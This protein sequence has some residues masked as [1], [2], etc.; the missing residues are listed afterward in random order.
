MK[1]KTDFVTNSSSSVFIVAWPCPIND[2]GDVKKHIWRDDKAIQVFKDVQHGKDTRQI[3]PKNRE[4]IDII[5]R[6]L[7][8][9][10]LQDL[11]QKVG[12]ELG[13]FD[14]YDKF[15]KDFMYR[16]DISQEELEKN[17]FS[18]SLMWKE[19]HQY[20]TK[21]AVILAE[22]FCKENKGNY[23]Y[24]FSYGDENGEFMSEMEHGGTFKDVPHIQVSHH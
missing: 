5:A 20:R 15:K 9:G 19:Y 3:D 17:N 16:H 24:F 4:M 10:F 23:L 13:M 18:S 12:V 21:V 7:E 22:K 11:G 1:I 2:L 6:E 14:G 8:S